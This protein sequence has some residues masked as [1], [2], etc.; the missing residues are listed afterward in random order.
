MLSVK[1][2]G[3]KTYPSDLNYP[4]IFGFS[5]IVSLILSRNYIPLSVETT[6]T[7]FIKNKL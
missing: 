7:L 2:D 4:I 1:I 3:I 6:N 5:M